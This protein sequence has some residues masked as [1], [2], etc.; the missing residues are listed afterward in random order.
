MIRNI[1]SALGLLTLLTGVTMAATATVELRVIDDKGKKIEGGLFM[2][3]FADDPT[4]SFTL[5]ENDAG[6]YAD[7]VQLPQDDTSWRLTRVVAGGYLPMMVSIDSTS[8]NGDSVQE[9]SAME[10]NPGVPVPPIRILAGGTTQ[11]ELTLGERSVVLQKYAQAREEIEAEEQAAAA[12]G[13]DAEYATALQLYNGGDVEGALPHFKQAAEQNPQDAEILE[14][15]A[16]VLYKAKRYEEFERTAHALLEIEPGNAE[17]VMMI[18]SS[19]RER[20]DLKAAL[21]A[22]LT[23][24]ELGAVSDNL[25]QHIDFV[26]RKLGQSTDAIPAYEAVLSLDENNVDACVA[27]A[28]LYGNAG[29]A[30]RSEEYLQRAVKLSPQRASTI[31]LE[32]S[33]KLLGDKKASADDLARAVELIRKAI[34]LDPSYPPPYKMLGLALWKQEDYTGTR[35]A[36]EKYLELYPD[37]E[38]KDQ[39]DDY[40]SRLP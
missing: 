23:V 14:T 40:L 19:A 8:R 38:D 22:L 25:L 29:D 9:V 12:P 28:S 24:K 7:S 30:A 5:T 16:N 33:S 18:Y 4:Q 3:S 20:G 37:A 13:V 10:L 34:D 31:Y 15:Y 17:L 11:I 26:A 35:E 1:G 32:M 2:F 27:L 21:D 6:A 39:I 36:F